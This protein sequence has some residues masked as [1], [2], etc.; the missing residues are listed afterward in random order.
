MK[1]KYTLCP[2]C[3][4]HFKGMASLNHV[5]TVYCRVNFRLLCVQSVLVPPYHT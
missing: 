5:Y 2:I 3:S 4:V 1:E